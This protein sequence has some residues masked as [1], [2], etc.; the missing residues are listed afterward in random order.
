[1]G[2]ISSIETENK[3][4]IAFYSKNISVINGI[5]QPEAYT[6][7]TTVEGLIWFGTASESYISD[8]I[9]TQVEGGLQVDYDAA[10]AV[11]EDNCR[12][13]VESVNYQVLHIE[14][15]GKQNEVLEVLFK[16]EDSN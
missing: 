13:V 9:K 6:L 12:I 14:N 5:P 15:V 4:S 2:F 3:I 1:M 10:I 8:K 11:L 7:V 16:R